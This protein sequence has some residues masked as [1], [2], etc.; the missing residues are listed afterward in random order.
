MGRRLDASG[1]LAAALGIEAAAACDLS[2]SDLAA[3]ARTGIGHRICYA[4][5]Q[6]ALAE[7]WRTSLEDDDENDVNADL[8]ERI[9][10]EQQ[11]VTALASSRALGGSWL[12]PVT[13]APLAEP[14]TVGRHEILELR[15]VT[16]RE[17]TAT[18][19]VSDRGA[20]GFGRPSYLSLS[21]ARGGA[22]LS[23]PRIHVSHLVYVPGA[24]RLPDGRGSDGSGLYDESYLALYH[25]AICRVEGAAT[26][27]G[28]TLERRGMPTVKLGA[29]AR[30]GN[31]I[32]AIRARL[33]ALREF[34]RSM[35]M[36]VVSALDDVTWANVPMGGTGE[37][38]SSLCQMVAVVEGA[39]LTWL[40]GIAPAGLSTDDAAGER[41]KNAL[42]AATQRTA[43]RCLQQIYDIADG[44]QPG[45]R[46]VWAPLGQPDGETAARTSLTAAQRDE[47]LI[48]SGVIMPSEA[49]ERYR[50]EVEA[51][52]PVLSEDGDIEDGDEEMGPEPA[53][54]PFA[55]V[56]E[57][58]SEDAPEA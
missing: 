38:W 26:A 17:A 51:A 15:V 7:G 6:A 20:K 16:A 58:D 44:P 21:G 31:T 1:W 29:D 11:L 52:M 41:S 3:L 28:L 40:L 53:A 43:T 34:M 42:L 14:L 37:A 47:V 12:W 30:S 9:G 48:R 24:P 13:A 25:A 46:I 27:L 18:E 33:E 8:D 10:T 23:V 22:T 2:L 35:R 45:R 56:E 4:V 55:P 49:R 50:G 57:E 5:P 36:L 19:W 39:P 54:D 32:D